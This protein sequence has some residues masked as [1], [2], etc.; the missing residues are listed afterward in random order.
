MTPQ[1]LLDGPSE[2]EIPS[3]KSLQD[4]IV[5]L[6][7][8][9]QRTEGKK[10]DDFRYVPE[11][12]QGDLERLRHL[13]GFL[14]KEEPA[15][16]IMGETGSYLENLARMIHLG[17][18]ANEGAWIVV[19]CGEFEES[20]IGLFEA[21][22]GGTLVLANIEKLSE[23]NQL[24]LLEILEAR[25]N[26]IMRGHS[27][28][29]LEARVIAL[30]T[31]RLK[32]M[33]KEGAFNK[34]LFA[35]LAQV[36][37][38]VAPLRMRKEEILTLANHFGKKSFSLLGKSFL[39]FTR[40]VEEFFKNYSWPGNDAELLLLLQRAALVA[41]DSQPVKMND[42][43][44]AMETLGSSPSITPEIP[45]FERVSGHELNFTNVKRKWT[46]SFEKEYLLFILN[47][48]LGNVSAAAREAKLDR[49]NFLRL[50]RRHGLKAEQF[51]H[52]TDSLK[53]VA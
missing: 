27:S 19:G 2:N 4:R 24:Q 21:A 45:S 16:L 53:L 46:T 17:S 49:S 8:R 51:R 33:V 5:E 37:I 28:V 10:E 29:A 6:E 12:T 38:D 25:S 3:L 7:L 36:T 18:R 20:K 42:F 44:Y 40:E 47:R 48:H 31:H 11:G 32:A 26:R 34:S 13:S 22:R 9:I 23:Q 30:G 43:G 15:V 14:D 50:L 35:V 41:D 1:I 39:G 52:E